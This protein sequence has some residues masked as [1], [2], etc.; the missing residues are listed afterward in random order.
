MSRTPRGHG[1]AFDL[2]PLQRGCATGSRAPDG[3]RRAGG[4]AGPA[5]PTHWAPP[6]QAAPRREGT[7]RLRR[8][9]AVPPRAAR[10]RVQVPSRAAGRPRSSGSSGG[11]ERGLR[12]SRLRWRTSFRR[13]ALPGLAEPFPSEEA[14]TEPFTYKQ[15]FKKE[16][17]ERRIPCLLQDL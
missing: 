4:R 13:G 11:G 6:L 17:S 14:N 7:V 12:A 8:A 9:R 16:G 10:L 15:N 5:V 3:P 2:P 1:A